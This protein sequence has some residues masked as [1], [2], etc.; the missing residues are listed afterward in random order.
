M[1]SD[2]ES[3]IMTTGGLKANTVFGNTSATSVDTGSTSFLTDFS[4][5]TSGGVIDTNDVDAIAEAEVYIAYGRDAQAE[6]ILKDAI[7]KEPQRYELHLKL[8]EMYAAS[9]N[10]SA[11]ETVSGELYTTLGAD[12]PTWSKVAAIGAKLEPDNPLYQMSESAGSATAAAAEPVATPAA[13]EPDAPVASTEGDLDASDF[14]EAPLASEEDL[15]FSLGEEPN[16]PA[17]DNLGAGVATAAVTGAAAAAAADMMGDASASL[18]V[19]ESVLNVK[20][21]DFDINN[22]GE[23]PSVAEPELNEPDFA[24]TLPSLDFPETE[25]NLEAEAA[26][27]KAPS[28]ETSAQLGEEALNMDFGEDP[29]SGADLTM[30]D[31]P[32]ATDLAMPS[33]LSLDMPDGADNAM[34]ELTASL[35]TPAA[36]SAPESVEF[37]MGTLEGAVES[38]ESA[39][40][41]VVDSEPNSLNLSELSLEEVET[42]LELVAAYIDMDDSEGAQELLE[43]VIKEGGGDQRKRAEAL[44][45]TL[46]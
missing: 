14:A 8:L 17:A 6:E 15:N 43:E 33:D 24:N 45:T 35:E 1:L 18:D 10:M 26:E 37:D 21:T 40:E 27:V 13:T 16:Q 34:T 36:E 29:T 12:D 31:A 4:Q 19:D 22:L 39:D 30:P 11:F 25:A 28:A 2:F 7:S 42:K 41:P 44:L 9:K 5:S 46:K 32:E 23:E 20:E 38:M 3:G